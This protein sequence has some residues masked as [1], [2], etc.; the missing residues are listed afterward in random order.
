MASPATALRS[1]A[2]AGE[3]ESVGRLIL[4]GVDVNVA[5]KFGRTALSL[6]AGG[7]HSR[8]VNQLIA[9]GAWADPHE[10]Y[11]TYETPLMAAAASGHFEIVRALVDAGADPKLHNGIAQR[12][13]EAYAR[14]N[15]HLGIA[16]FLAAMAST[17]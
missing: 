10:D 5:D 17:R 8:V 1:A 2:Y 15:G 16:D 4:E 3:S 9:A 7:G 14:E 11:D 13:A 12:T 6:A